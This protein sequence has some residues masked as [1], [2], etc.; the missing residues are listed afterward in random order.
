MAK[1]D[2]LERLDRARIDLEAEYRAALITALENT[3]AGSWGIFGHNDHLWTDGRTA[4]TRDALDDLAAA[5]DAL[6]ER[7][8]MDPFALHRDFRAARGPVGPSA[9]G[10]RRQA[11]AWLARLRDA[12]PG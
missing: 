5:I 3:A 10:E 1:A 8:V 4:A 9:P 7:L 6:R 12:T 11:Q 2:R